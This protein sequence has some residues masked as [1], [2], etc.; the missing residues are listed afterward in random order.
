LATL[1]AAIAAATLVFSAVEG[2]EPRSPS[3]SDQAREL[4]QQAQTSF[5]QGDTELAVEL[6]QGAL[7]NSPSFHVARFELARILAWVGRFEDSSDQFA[8]IVAALPTNGAARRGLVTAQ[9]F[10]AR[11]E[12][13][14]HE[15][16]EGLQA[17]PRDGQLAHTLARLLAT[18][19]VEQVRDGALALQL[20]LT[21]YEVK[22]TYDTGETVAMA[23]AEVGDF[24]S[25]IE[26]QRSLIARAQNEN[27]E[28]KVEALR[29]KLLSYLRSE[30]WRAA[31]PGEI[32]MATEPPAA[33]R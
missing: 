26:K 20:A 22:Q 25:A 1:A 33:P 9:L 18:A 14:R 29:E 11:Y 28:A 23:H 3:A 16:E 15:L 19:P 4:A 8:I 31:S 30:P 27:D 32:A 24:E 7:E 17:S 21:V 12:D 10:L 13:A 2:Q 5:R 6:Y